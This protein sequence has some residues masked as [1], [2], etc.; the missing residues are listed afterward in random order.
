MLF[1]SL[2][3]D[4]DTKTIACFIE[5]VRRPAAFLAVAERALQVGKPILVLK[6]GRSAAAQEAAKSH[7]GALTGDDT[8]FDAMCAK[9]GVMRCHALDD[10]IEASLVFEHGRRPAGK[11]IGAV[12]TS[13]GA[14]GLFLDHG[15]EVGVS[16]GALS[17]ATCDAL[18]QIG[19]AHV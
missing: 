1:R 6:V 3:D 11:R 4:P 19:R 7:T 16:F 2:I 5:G 15:A 12:L 18:A 8:V 17:Q 10:L 14:R 13:G 9:Y